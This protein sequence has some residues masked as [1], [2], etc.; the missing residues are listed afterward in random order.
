M[1]LVISYD[2]PDNLRRNHL[3]K[4]LLDYGERKQES[5]FEARLSDSQFQTLLLRIKKTMNEQEDNIRI[6]Y[7]CNS[8]LGKTIMFGKTET[9]QAE[10]D[11]YIV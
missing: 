11:F 6:Y 8:C 4:I 1:H 5:L 2:I 3:S 9:I 10:P 7:L